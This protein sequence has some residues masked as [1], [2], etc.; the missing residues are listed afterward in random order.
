MTMLSVIQDACV[1]IGIPKPLAIASNTA[2][3]AM[4]LLRLLNAGA[5]QLMKDHHW[6]KLIKVTTFT[7]VAAQAQTGSPPA[8]FDRFAPGTKLWDVNKRLP[9]VGPLSAEKWLVILAQ[10]VTGADKYWTMIDGVINI[11]P[12][13]TVSDSFRYTLVSRYY[14]RPTGNS[15]DTNDKAAFTVDTDESRLSEELLTL[16]LVWRWKKMK[17]LDYAEDLADFERQK[18]MDIAADR[19]AAVIPTASPFEK[20]DGWWPGTVT[21]V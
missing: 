15:D 19:V 7:G 18:E 17:Q 2:T 3:D 16:D 14:A 13:P 9:L 10:N 6:S 5:K 11:T 1:H 20:P 4:Q 8:R 21:Q 12:T